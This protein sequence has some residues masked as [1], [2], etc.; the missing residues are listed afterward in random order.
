MQITF[1]TENFVRGG[2]D[3]SLTNALCYLSRYGCFPDGHYPD[4][5]KITCRNPSSAYRYCRYFAHKGISPENEHVFLKNPLIGVRYLKGVGR[6]EFADPNTQKRFRKKFSTNAK[7]AYQWCKNFGQ[8][9]TEKEEEVFRK[10][11]CSAYSYARDVI[12]GKFPEKVHGMIILASFKSMTAYE[13]RALSD[14]V[15]FSER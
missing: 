8:R 11:V 9:L 3:K 4:I 15:K 1:D 13:K 2:G 12:R 5:E 7:L 14:Y 10:D 6:S